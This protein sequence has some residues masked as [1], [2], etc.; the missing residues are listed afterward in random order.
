MIGD[1]RQWLSR[2][3]VERG[4]IEVPVWYGGA[5]ETERDE[6]CYF[7]EWETEE[8]RDSEIW[9]FQNCICPAA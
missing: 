6:I 3:R 9:Y 7:G 8:W 2:F 1:A 5:R 4:K